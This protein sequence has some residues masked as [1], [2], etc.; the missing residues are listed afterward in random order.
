M[1][2]RL[3]DKP[4]FPFWVDK[5]IFGS[6]R[7]ECSLEERAIWVDL[8][9]IASKDDGYIRANEKTSYPLCQLAGMLMIPEDKLK[10]A[11]QRFIELDKIEEINSGIYY[12]KTWPKYQLSE[13]Y[14]RVKKHRK[15]ISCN[16]EALQ[17][18]GKTLPI[19]YQIISNKIKSKEE[20]DNIV[21]QIISYFNEKTGQKRSS[22]CDETIRLIKGRLAEGR[23]IE[24][25]KYVIDIKVAKWKGKSWIDNRTGKEVQG[26]DFLRPSTLFRPGN[27][28]DYLNEQIPSRK[29]TD[30]EFEARQEEALRRGGAHPEIQ[31]MTE[32]DIEYQKARKEK[33]D[34]IERKY[35]AEIKI[36]KETGNYGK[37]GEKIKEEIAEFSR[38]YFKEKD[39]AKKIEENDKPI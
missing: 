12:I 9:A 10:Q 35:E 11:I 23:T 37:I 4:W 22:T 13:S 31:K 21:E 20:K 27:F 25:F 36:A 33:M 38:K 7:I 2:K 26:D 3:S 17:C 16:N 29:D 14:E 15:K 32:E 28:E 5:W 6:M 30:E 39:V 8:L 24:D 1:K 18:N 19:S 34:E